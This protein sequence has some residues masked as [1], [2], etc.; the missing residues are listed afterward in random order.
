MAI[1]DWPSIDSKLIL[2]D[3]PEMLDM[4]DNLLEAIRVKTCN[5]GYRILPINA[6]RI[7]LSECKN[8]R[9]IFGYII[10][11]ELIRE[12]CAKSGIDASDDEIKN[13]LKFRFENRNNRRQQ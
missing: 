12:I 6:I 3:Q 2:Y 7:I 1:I 11:A 4:R 13:V 10:T 9:E 5:F 8:A